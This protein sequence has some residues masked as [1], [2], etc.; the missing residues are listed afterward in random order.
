VSPAG[1]PPHTTPSLVAVVALGGLVGAP[2]RYA[3]AQALPGPGSGWP[4]ATFTTNLL[5]A[6]VLGVLLEALVRS[7]ADTGGRR[8]LRLGLGTG[9][10]GAFTTYSTLALEVDG[11]ARG[12][13]VGTAVAYALASVVGGVLAAGAGVALGARRG[14]R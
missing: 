6:L 2:L 5:G 4:T 12:G 3:V 14:R 7:G 9:V 13:R 10:V 8:L 11:L 1:R